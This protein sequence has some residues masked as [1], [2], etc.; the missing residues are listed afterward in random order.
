MISAEQLEIMAPAFV[1]GIIVALAH[2]PLGIEVLR[3]GII[4]ID[5]AIAQVAGLAIVTMQLIWHE[6]SWLVVQS[7]AAISAI[8]TAAFFRW[9]EKTAPR[10]QEAVI[11]S[12]FILAASGTLLALANHPR[13]GEEIQH[14]LSGQILFAT[15]DDIA[16]AAPILGGIL[17]L[18]L[19]SS[20]V[21][22][23]IG[24]FLL[25]AL[26]ITVSV[27]LVGVY[28]VFASL[29]LPALAVNIRTLDRSRLTLAWASGLVAVT[30]GIAISSQADLPAGPIL[31]VTFAV[32]AI[33]FRLALQRRTL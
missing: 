4:F 16:R 9:I 21:R 32:S 31:V 14:I 27:R 1:A 6:P 3:R 8:A 17:V 20:R 18:W 30:A 15:W 28:V 11:G 12:C 33:C 5:L 23:G 7:M 22:D 29:I 19:T 13:G 10:E 24:F 25:F 2:A 26:A